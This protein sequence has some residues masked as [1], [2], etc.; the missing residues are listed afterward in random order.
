MPWSFTDQNPNR[1]TVREKSARSS[2]SSFEDD[3]D[4]DDD[5]NAQQQQHLLLLLLDVVVVAADFE[6]DDGEF[7]RR[8]KE[9][10]LVAAVV[11]MRCLIGR[12]MGF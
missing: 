7:E 5:D 3:S 6:R 9:D 2:S 10:P 11:R 4:D 1:R 12:Q 8:A